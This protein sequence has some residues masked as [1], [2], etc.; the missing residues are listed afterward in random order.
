M[1]CTAKFG[2]GLVPEEQSFLEWRGWKAV[3]VGVVFG[4]DSGIGRLLEMWSFEGCR[5]SVTFYWGGLHG[6]IWRRARPGRTEFPDME[7]SGS[8]FWWGVFGRRF[9]DRALPWNVEFG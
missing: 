1:D 8:C 2:A 6:Q 4:V 7:R 3:F 9:G 5:M